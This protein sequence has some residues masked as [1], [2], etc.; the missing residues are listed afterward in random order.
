MAPA[1]QR[2]SPADHREQQLAALGIYLAFATRALDMADAGSLDPHAGIQRFLSR[3]C[4]VRRPPG[5]STRSA[6]PET[7]AELAL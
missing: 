5:R 1:R 6:A 4:A 7:T 3:G 2:G